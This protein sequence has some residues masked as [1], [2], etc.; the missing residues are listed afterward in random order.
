MDKVETG[1]RLSMHSA[2]IALLLP[3]AGKRVLDIGC[4]KGSLVRHFAKNGAD[5]VGLDPQEEI[6]AEAKEAAKRLPC[7]FEVGSA[8]S[9]PYPDGSFDGT[10]FFN[11]L[12]HVPVAMMDKA[13]DEALRVTKDDGRMLIV[14]PLAEGVYFELTRSI[15]DE[16]EVRADAL[17]AMRRMEEAGK[18]KEVAEEFYETLFVYDDYVSFE[19]EMIAVD[20]SRETRLV[21]ERSRLHPKFHRVAEIDEE[22]RFCFRH[23]TRLNLYRKS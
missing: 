17:A 7:H 22:N 2:E 14:E 5:A 16:T 20:P 13:L 12:H 10:V 19:A 9:L 6:I 18:A 21:A 11:S 4:G 8:E 3:Q 23:P 15:D 1:Y